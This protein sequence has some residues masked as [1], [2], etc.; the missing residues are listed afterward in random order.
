MMYDNG[1]M[2]WGG[3][4]LVFLVLLVLF[5]LLAAL[6]VWVVSGR[7]GAGSASASGGVSSARLILDERLARG[8]IDEEEYRRRRAA[9]DG[10]V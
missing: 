7:G 6:L 9:L 4:F 8:E 1:Y 2:G 10:G 3:L 5:G